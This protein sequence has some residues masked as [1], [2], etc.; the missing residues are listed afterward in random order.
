MF[1][2]GVVEVRAVCGVQTHGVVAPEAPGRPGV[3]LLNLAPGRPASASP[4]Q[5]SISASLNSKSSPI[6]SP[7]S[8][9]NDARNRSPGFA[10]SMATRCTTGTPL[11]PKKDWTGKRPYLAVADSIVHETHFGC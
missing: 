9:P 3:D 5:R 4:T 6:C 8:E 1:L 11:R 7:R 10:G 2:G